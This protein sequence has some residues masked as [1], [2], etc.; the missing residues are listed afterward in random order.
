MFNQALFE[1]LLILDDEVIQ[2]TPVPWVRALEDVARGTEAE[3]T[4]SSQTPDW[5]LEQG[6]GGVV[7]DRRR[8]RN[9]MAPE[10]GAMV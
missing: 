3:S 5:T 6:P 7:R 10:T 8:A 4:E 9:T 2:A 1:R